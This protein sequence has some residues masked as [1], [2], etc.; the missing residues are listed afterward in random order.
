MSAPQISTE[1][2]SRVGSYYL[3]NSLG[4]GGMGEVYR[5]RH[6][7]ET[8]AKRQGGDVAIKLMHPQYAKKLHFGSDSIEKRVLV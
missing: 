1:P 5:A 6:I 8:M 3:Y 7:N 4:K 2:V